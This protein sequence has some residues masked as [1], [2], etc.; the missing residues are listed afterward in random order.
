MFEDHLQIQ[1]KDHGIGI[2]EEDK[3]HLFERFFRGNNVMNIQGTGLGLS[4][5]ARYVELLKGEITVESELAKGTTFAIK[6]PNIK[7][8]E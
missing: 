8:D 3:K 4:I 2:T 1:I 7:N 5:V 6:I